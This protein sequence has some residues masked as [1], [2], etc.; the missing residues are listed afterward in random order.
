MRIEAVTPEE[1][2]GRKRAI[3]VLGVGNAKEGAVGNSD[4]MSVVRARKNIWP[5]QRSLRWSSACHVKE[6]TALG[7]TNAE[8]ISQT[9]AVQVRERCVRIDGDEVELH[10][11]KR[12]L[13]S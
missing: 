2:V 11:R 7:R 6:G 1:T 9:Q 12:L 3:S 8:E 4:G 10:E 13:R 5:R